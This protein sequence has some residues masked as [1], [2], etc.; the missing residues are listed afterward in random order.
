MN[1]EKKSDRGSLV[2]FVDDELASRSDGFVSRGLDLLGMQANVSV[3]WLV[4]EALAQAIDA[5]D[6]TDQGHIR[7]VQVYATG[8][9][10][11]L[12]MPLTEIQGVKTAAL[13]HD[14]GKLAGPD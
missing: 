1:D 9:A 7:R 5:K 13:L 10:K 6:Q 14:I 8:L 4:V 11:A 3:A 12:G 2:R